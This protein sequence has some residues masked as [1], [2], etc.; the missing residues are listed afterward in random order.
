[1]LQEEALISSN[2]SRDLEKSFSEN[3]LT[4]QRC[5]IPQPKP[6]HLRLRIQ[7]YVVALTASQDAAKQTALNPSAP[8]IPAPNCSVRR[9]MQ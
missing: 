9:Q 3:Q 6:P 7:D 1:M 4:V 5:L 8:A 2:F